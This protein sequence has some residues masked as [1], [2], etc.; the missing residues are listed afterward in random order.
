MKTA[1]S[2]VLNSDQRRFL[3]AQ[4]QRARAAAQRAAADALRAL[5]VGELSRP[6][7]LSDEQNK[8]RLALRDKG[9]QLGDDTLQAAVPPTNLIHDV[10][11]E[12]WH[13]LLFA[14]FLEVNG[15][16]RHP[17]FR[18]IPLSLE[19]CGDL[20]PDLDEPDEWAVAAR[21]AS[22]ILPG[23]FR[24]NDPAVQVR[25][26]AEHRNALEQLLLGIPAE[27]FTTEDALGWVYQFWQSAEKKRVNDSG[28]KIGGADLSPV[29]QLFTENYMVRFLLEN[30]LGAWWASQHPESPLVDSW[31][32]LRRNDDGS[33]ATGSFGDWPE[34]AAD[35]T[36]MDPCCGSGHFLVAMF[37]MLW[38]MRAE[39]EE[40]ST[41]DAQDAV[42]RDNLHGLELDPRC[43]QIATFNVVLDAWK[44]SGGWRQ[45]PTPNIACSGVAARDS[46]EDWHRGSGTDDAGIR[47]VLSRLH[48]LFVSADDY[49]SLLDPR[50]VAA[51]ASGIGQDL[52]GVEWENVAV[53]LEGQ[54]GRL[55]P[56]AGVLGASISS[57][58]SSASML[59]K[60]YDL[61]ATNVPYRS[62]V[63]L[64]ERILK[65]IDSYHI[66]AGGDLATAFVD[67]CMRL[68]KTC[69][70]VTPQSWLFQP[71]YTTFRKRLLEQAG[72]R[73]LAR[74]GSGAFSQI[75]GEV[76]NVA[77]VV[78]DSQTIEAKDA[79]AYLDLQAIKGSA[80]KASASRSQAIE[81]YSQ[82]DML[83]NPDARVARPSPGTHVLLAD[84]A[85]SSQGICTGDYPRFGRNFW[86]LPTIAGGWEKQQSTVKLPTM[87]GGREW[88][89]L[90][91]GGDGTLRDYV[92]ARLG[93]GRE[94]SWIRGIDLLGKRGVVISQSGNLKPT[95]YN[96]EL[97]DN[98]AA[99]IVPADEADLPALW[100][101]SS[102]DEYRQLVRNI[103][104]ALKV[105]NQ[106]LVKVPFDVERWRE[107]ASLAGPIP[108]PW[109]NDPTQWL[110]LGRPEDST[111]PLQVAVARLLGYGWPDQEPDELDRFADRDGIAALQSLPREPD[112]AT[113]LRELL[114]A[115]YGE[116][117][118]SSVERKLVVDSGGKNGR[119]E[120]WLRDVFFTQHVK[121]F[122]NRPFLWHIW[123]GRKDGFSAILN[124][125]KFGRQNLEKLTFTY[126][127]AWIERQHHEVAA[128]QAG[129]DA[130]LAAAEALQTK[131]KL[132]L[133]G[134]PPYDVYVRWKQ[135]HEQ[136]IGWNPDHNDGVRLNIRP[137]I[138]AG[139]L[140]T[141]INVH[142]KKDRGANLDGSERLNDLHPTLD[143]RRTARRQAE[144]AE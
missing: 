134:A 102:S 101:F 73:L 52:F 93:E 89:L 14:R 64:S 70:I 34:R 82:S 109:S 98:N 13:R 128:N 80:E 141:K 40:L 75:G 74:L 30:S 42:L 44:S 48:E 60:H 26:A 118:S 23:V 133:E 68:A 99:A 37:G 81:L 24:L 61:C 129:A 67:R 17:E 113:R 51:S 11:Y 95:L 119:L 88:I 106:T 140:R 96:G 43:V 21:F 142:W 123:D 111:A 77:L 86:E 39:E 114:A 115:A 32:Y 15:L 138:E 136:P 130:R 135:P 7:Y 120:D 85:D 84:R 16:L 41:A 90:W 19:D 59:S 49:G 18:D 78:A 132:I 125:H 8:L 91:E 110:F 46:V 137:F 10:A 126:L 3:D 54:H 108:E 12:Q 22:E 104:S 38:R 45:L 103:D 92:R 143:E 62:R 28:V 6:S 33:P 117:W 2:T 144:I 4:T 36:V 25:F 5:A 9:R 65:F 79:F 139:I 71:W 47:D 56:A 57:M 105:T 29:T 35:V 131:L 87:Y 116:E 50:R 107:E 112:L 53:I 122:G 72:W 55:D 97:L 94:G 76:V 100:A 31:I 121:I 20:A 58:A 69:A 1:T 66:D 127:G 63:S 27:V 83:G 124:Y